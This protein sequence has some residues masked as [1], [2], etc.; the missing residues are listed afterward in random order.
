[1]E[2]SISR[3]WWAACSVARRSAVA[4]AAASAAWFLTLAAGSWSPAR[5]EGAEAQERPPAVAPGITVIGNGTAGAQ[6]NATL[7]RLGVEVT[8]RTAIEALSGTR[9]R[10]ESV[11]QRLRGLGIADAQLQTTGVSVYPIMGPPHDGPGDRAAVTGYRGS[12]TIS[13]R[14]LTTDAARLGAV[15]SAAVEAGANAVHGVTFGVS[16]DRVLQ[17][18]A[19]VA[20]MADAQAKAGAI[21]D[22]AGLRL[23][24]IDAVVEVPVSGPP[25]PLGRGGPE[26]GPDGIAPGELT[27][28]A[29]VE[30][31][32]SV[33]IGTSA[34]GR[35][36]LMVP[37]GNAP[38]EPRAG[39]R[40]IPLIATGDSGAGGAVTLEPL[41]D[42]GLSLT[43]TATGLKPGS[44]Y[45]AVLRGGTGNQQ[46]ASVGVLG[47]LTAGDDGRGSLT[48]TEVQV[49]GGAAPLIV[50]LLAD[51]DRTITLVGPGGG[52]I[53]TATLLAA[54]P[55]PAP[56]AP[57][58]SAP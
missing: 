38:T 5:A 24:A 13:T 25:G 42:D 52:T 51:Q 6:P 19:L 20:A 1:M 33:N 3:A 15:L 31:T 49:A 8:G 44:A 26:V 41:P 2:S 9:Q 58:A 18:Q 36:S 40:G 50:S 46:S 43:I 29:R 55:P 57:D 39:E 32:Y 14:L 12:A 48:T 10:S 47:D 34:T 27:V 22:A 16:D 56:S 7:V 23:G 17:Q 45:R 21:A 4:I 11:L 28:A 35:G 54:T 30:V 37:A 53:A